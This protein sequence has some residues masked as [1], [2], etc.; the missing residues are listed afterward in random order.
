[1]AARGDIA[2]FEWLRKN[3]IDIAPGYIFERAAAERQKAFIKYLHDNDKLTEGYEVM[4]DTFARNNDVD[5]MQFVRDYCPKFQYSES[6]SDVSIALQQG[7]RD[8]IQFLVEHGYDHTQLLD[9][10]QE[11]ADEE[12]MHFIQQLIR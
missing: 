2:S 4:Y 9:V 3:H 6:A 8:Y 12:M 7:N 11:D 10:A 1:L 5:M